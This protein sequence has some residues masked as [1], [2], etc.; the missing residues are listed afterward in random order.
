MEEIKLI[1]SYQ[2]DREFC[3]GLRLKM[4]IRFRLLLAFGRWL[5][6]QCQVYRQPA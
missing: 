2:I 3:P 6:R 5:Q 1:K 4:I